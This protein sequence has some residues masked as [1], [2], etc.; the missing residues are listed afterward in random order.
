[1]YVSF[2]GGG[3][4]WQFLQQETCNFAHHGPATACSNLTTSAESSPTQRSSPSRHWQPLFLANLIFKHQET[5][6]VQYWFL[7]NLTL[8]SSSI[9]DKSPSIFLTCS[10]PWRTVLTRKKKKKSTNRFSAG[11][12]DQVLSHLEILIIVLGF[13]QSHRR[14]VASSS[15]SRSFQYS[16][17][18][19]LSVAGKAPSRHGRSST[20]WYYSNNNGTLI[21]VN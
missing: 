1:M 16:I 5:G 11:Q 7:P 3:L 2:R 14:K 21:H 20:G 9:T 15:S 8:A 6:Y 18:L 4:K 10:D 13:K 17:D 19:I 12:K